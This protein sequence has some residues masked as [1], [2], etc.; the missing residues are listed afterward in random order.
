MC[1]PSLFAKG[2]YRYYYLYSDR[3]E[4]KEKE[5]L[6]SF[7]GIHLSLEKHSLDFLYYFILVPLIPCNTLLFLNP[8]LPKGP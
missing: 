1:V 5:T 2:T 7:L 6:F 8:G 4:C 3:D